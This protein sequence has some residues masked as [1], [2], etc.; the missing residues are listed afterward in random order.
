MQCTNCG[1][2]YDEDGDNAVCCPF[3]DRPTGGFPEPYEADSA[4]TATNHSY[5]H[6]LEPDFTRSY[7]EG[8]RVDHFISGIGD[9]YVRINKVRNDGSVIMSLELKIHEVRN[10]L[11]ILTRFVNGDDTADKSSE[12]DTPF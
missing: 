2:E 8:A 9:P 10:L 4:S 6:P 11:Q 12:D 7:A 1:R 5:Y 3:C